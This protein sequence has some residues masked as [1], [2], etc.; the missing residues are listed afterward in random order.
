MKFL[1]TIWLF[2]WSLTGLVG[3][4]ILGRLSTPTACGSD[5]DET[6]AAIE[7]DYV[8]AMHS[9]AFSRQLDTVT[10]LPTVVHII[11]DDGPENLTDAQIIVGIDRL[12]DAMRN[13][14]I[15]YSPQGVDTKLEFCLARRHIDGTVFNGI[16]RYR[17]AFTDMR[18]AL[19]SDRDQLLADNHWP[20]QDYINIRTVR[21]ACTGARCD[22]AGFA[23]SGKGPVII[24]DVFKGNVD[25]IKVL[26][27]ELGHYCILR[28]TFSGGCKNDNCLEDGD[29]VCDT[30]PDNTDTYHCTVPLNSCATDVDDVRPVNPFRP[31]ALGGL[32]DRLDPSDNY[33]DYNFVDCKNHLTPGQRNRWLFFLRRLYPDLP[34]S[35]ACLPPC[36]QP[37][38]AHFNLDKDTFS[39]GATIR[40]QNT[41]LQDNQYFWYLDDTLV[42]TD[43]HPVLT[44]Q[45][46]G[47]ST[48]KLVVVPDDNRCDATSATATVTVI[49]PAASCFTY[50]SI[51]DTVRWLS[52]AS[53][54]IDQRIYI[55]AA[56][57]DTVFTSS[58]KADQFILPTL[59]TYLICQTTDN[60]SCSHT[61]CHAVAYRPAQAEVCDNSIDDDQDGFVDGFDPDCPCTASSY[62]DLCD[63]SCQ[64][65]PDLAS[66]G[67]ALKWRSEVMG[68]SISNITAYQ[69]PNEHFIVCKK[70][71]ASSVFDQYSNHVI[72]I[73][74][75]T[76][77]TRNDFQY[78]DN[79]SISHGE[80]PLGFC[81]HND[82]I[83]YVFARFDSL[84]CM[85]E[86][87]FMLWRKRMPNTQRV[88]I[89]FADFNG[90]GLPEIYISNK[91]VSIFN[92]EVLAEDVLKLGGNSFGR[93]F[94]EGQIP[95]ANFSHANTI[96]ADFLPS[97][98]L[99]LAA[100]NVVYEVVLNNNLSK[101]GN[102]LIAH[103]ALPP[104]QNGITSAG[105]I[106]GDGLLEVIVVRN[107]YYIDGGGIYVW[108]PRTSALIAQAPSGE[109]GSVAFIG[110]VDGDCRPE[111]GVVFSRELRM[112]RYDNTDQLALMYN[113]GTTDVSGITGITMFDFNQDGRH[114]LIY[115]D[116]TT[117]RILEGATG[118]TLATLPFF[119]GTG[120]EYPIVVDVDS[121]GHAEIV[122]SGFL[123]GEKEADSR[124][125]CFETD[126]QPWAPARSVW[127]QYGYHV[128][129]ILDD[130]TV[131]KQPQH[132]AQFFDTDSCARATCPQPYNAFITQ[133]T[134]RSQRGCQVWPSVPDL[135]V[136]ATAACAADSVDVCIIVIGRPDTMTFVPFSCYPLP[137]NYVPG[138]DHPTTNGILTP[139]ETRIIQ[140]EDTIC[141]RMPRMLGL[142]SMLIIIN[143][144]GEMGY[145]L[146]NSAFSSVKTECQYDNNTFILT[147][148]AKLENVDLGP[149]ITSCAGKVITLAAPPGY[150]GYLWNDASTEE[151]YTTGVNGLHYVEA[152]DQC[153]YITKDTMMLQVTDVIKVDL[154][155]DRRICP[156]ESVI[157]SYASPF[158]QLYWTPSQSVVCDTC[159]N[160]TLNQNKTT[161]IALFVMRDGCISSDTLVVDVVEVTQLDLG[162]E[163]WLCPDSKASMS[164]STI[165]DSLYWTPSGL[166]S[167]DTCSLIQWQT[168]ENFT[169]SVTAHQQGCTTTDSVLIKYK[170]QVAT[171]QR[172][173]LC[174]Q[175]TFTYRDSTW[176]QAGSF[177][178]AIGQCDTLYTF[179]I[180]KHSSIIQPLEADICIG[181]S[182]LFG[183]RYIKESGLYTQDLFT[184]QGCD[185][186][187]T[188]LLKQLPNPSTNKTLE[189]CSG[190]D[191]FIHGIR[192]TAPG[193]YDQMFTA[194][195]GCDSLSSVQLIWQSTLVV[196]D[197]VQACVDE[198]VIIHGI[199][200]NVAGVYERGYQSIDGCDSIS[201][202]QL[203]INPSTFIRDTVHSC[204]NQSVL[205]HGILRDTPGLYE[206]HF[207]GAIGCD[208]TS[209]VL[210]IEWPEIL[211]RD[212][213]QI[214][215][216]ESAVIHGVPRTTQGLYEQKFTSLTGCD[217]TS[218]VFLTISPYKV[219]TQ[220]HKL[221]EGQSISI[222]EMI[223]T[224]AG[225]YLDTIM[226]N[227]S[228]D[229]IVRHEVSVLS[230]A[231]TTTQAY[232]CPDSSRMINGLLI[233]TP[234][235]YVFDQ[236][237][238]S[239]GCDSIVTVDV[240]AVSPSERPTITVDC[241]E[242]TY[243]I[244]AP[245]SQDWSYI[246]P[247]GNGF[248]TLQVNK[249][250]RIKI[251]ASS[252]YFCDKTYD[253]DLPD[254]PLLSDIPTIADQQQSGIA[255]VTVSIDLP[256]SDWKV[257]WSPSALASCDTC[258]TTTI[259]TDQDT[260]ITVSLTHSSGCV[261]EQSFRMSRQKTFGFDLP[262]IINVTSIVGND[263]WIWNVP[264][265][266][267][268]SHCAIYDRWGNQVYTV[269]NTAQISWDGRHLDVEVLQ[270]VYVYF[271]KLIDPNGTIV[272]LKGDLTVVR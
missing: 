210:L 63:Q 151:T 74:G 267:M 43:R 146:L 193:V 155:A 245:P 271:I 160:T 115:R 59:D 219:T 12:N 35:K 76:G 70:Q 148:P 263:T 42:S 90:D 154:G 93:W 147:L 45:T 237:S 52:C 165:Y 261:F 94:P 78:T 67:F 198:T 203:I 221:C 60:D 104:V 169:L 96:A 9:L 101:V 109:A 161:T 213:I 207:A 66:I 187:V 191:I 244:I 180:Q 10:I 41:T 18:L 108:N 69:K 55:I 77:I 30:P 6:D 208:S 79:T 177:T 65:V 44:A 11:H 145:N 2:S 181:D 269:Q 229:L 265:G 188:L 83:K 173:D 242:N 56:N 34:A 255:G 14:G 91:I 134:Y 132:I 217:S 138:G 190:K 212:T 68:S 73:D 144:D 211:D 123:A 202:V 100:G 150:T 196:K 36:D 13:R 25:Y 232:L 125:Y 61:D 72:Q 170:T 39:I 32:G 107:Q 31:V 130:L 58:N 120:M 240:M 175:D 264:T 111:I 235:R 118:L 46:A 205:I 81:K 251:Q 124:V 129:N 172:I 133:A 142:D 33:M 200:R 158:D 214:C 114:E 258:M 184:I 95:A 22:I 268:L 4:A 53:D 17:S 119:S 216:G 206:Q 178:Y 227:I 204:S 121:D 152:T 84:Y 102:S 197:T 20:I 48:L 1:C 260:M 226:S 110:D 230:N 139:L 117:L 174:D 128:T 24:S 23:G 257:L 86:Y 179:D 222:N 183:S 38:T 157:L 15:Y 252:I 224:T 75:A 62:F 19:P 218:N 141:A 28:H 249:G 253:F 250:G 126:G 92:G 163:L 29:R 220:K 80:Y 16:K 192:R 26:V 171:S 89:N 228:C 21:V 136:T 243:T 166:L 199:Q 64:S 270:G 167:C 247:N 168:N 272:I 266:Y 241:K 176:A 85:D 87:G 8:A 57:Q 113:L 137:D 143:D 97:P 194:T 186:T 149:D 40:P 5:T 256:P 189:V 99:E 239:L 164:V 233:S 103:P 238:T 98:G 140:N 122:T 201:S 156:D 105:D 236:F 71:I 106:D 135:Q 127:N 37:I 234:G 225:T 262:N 116:M 185:S 7:A 209:A 131:P 223:V 54:Y 51:K 231:T 3:Q 259:T 47:T 248:D 195:N 82:T 27:H 162:V 215:P 182:L 246:A 153:G 254:I 112:Y 88:G 159:S 50:E 49:C